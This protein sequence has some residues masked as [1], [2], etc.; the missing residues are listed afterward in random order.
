MAMRKIGYLLPVL[1]TFTAFFSLGAEQMPSALN[2]YL[3]DLRIRIF[4]AVDSQAK[5]LP[6]AGEV[7]LKICVT[8]EG[9]LKDIS[10][11]SSSGDSSVDKLAASLVAKAFP[12]KPLPSSIKDEELWLDIPLQFGAI[13][14][15]IFPEA[16][17]P[18]EV[19]EK[20]PVP[21]VL[22]IY[23]DIASGNYQPTRIAQEQIGLAHIKIKEAQR[24]LYPMVS[25]EIKSS[26]G[27]T[28]T[29]PY[30]S[31]SYGIRAEQILIGINQYQDTVHRERLGLR[32]A[33]KNYDRLKSNLRYDLTKAYYELISQKMLLAHWKQ[34]M[35]E[36]EDILKVVQKLSDAKLIV[37]TEFDNAQ[38]Q[39]KLSQF[40][41]VGAESAFSLAKL[42][43]LQ[44]M[45]LES[46]GIVEDVDPDT[47]FGFDPQ[48]L[49]VDLSDCIKIALKWRPEI[50]VWQMACKSARINEVINKKENEPKLSMITTYG[51][52][53]EAY[54]N[55]SLSMVDEWSLMG[56]LSWL[57]GPNSAEFVQSRDRTLPKSI[58]DTTTKTNS[59]S[60]DFKFSLFDRLNYYSANKEARI[61]YR[62]SVSELNETKKKAVFEVK[63]AYFAYKRSISGIQ[64]S[65]NRLEYRQKE[66]KLVDTRVKVGEGS[67]VDL[68]EAKMNLAQ[69]KE[70]YLRSVGE[71]Y[72]AVAALDKATGYQL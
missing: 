3:T 49:S 23:M 15:D 9:L 56:R 13:K 24:N 59:N 43:L 7:K 41:V 20:I 38:S 42:T 14:K 26:D 71:Y 28:L 55:Q 70:S 17:E 44:I 34:I 31:R 69:D 37:P 18:F 65:K 25:G 60:S 29:D 39:Y 2:T 11:D 32:M 16:Q 48:D 46:Q 67:P 40:R 68:I 6:Q 51:R 45:N 33:Q 30:R 64:A 58:T 35:E 10:V 27:K 52:S 54:S 8:Q 1:I 66:Y 57:W 21:K 4:H 5:D 19:P 22:K 12:F 53:G 47:D 63:D 50:E 72:L 62:Q 36:T 61:T